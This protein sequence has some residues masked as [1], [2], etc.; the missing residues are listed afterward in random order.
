MPTFTCTVSDAPHG[1]LRLDRYVAEN[2]CLL[3]R[4]QIKA[5][6]LGAKVNGRQ[7]KVSHPVKGGPS[8]TFLEGS[9]SC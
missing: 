9:G 1:G 6:E 2:L 4:S 8:G 7:A 3:S 5:R